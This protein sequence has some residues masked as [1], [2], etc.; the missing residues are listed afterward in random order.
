MATGRVRRVRR[1]AASRPFYWTDAELETL[2]RL[3]RAHLPTA[4]IARELQRSP[5]AVRTKASELGLSLAGYHARKR[6]ARLQEASG[7]ADPRMI[8]SSHRPIRVT[9]DFDVSALTPAER[10][11]LIARLQALEPPGDL[12][13]PKA[14]DPAVAAA[15]RLAQRKEARAA[16]GWDNSPKPEPKPAVSR[17]ELRRLKRAAKLAGWQERHFPRPGVR[18]EQVLPPEVVRYLKA[19][20]KFRGRDREEEREFG[21]E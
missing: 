2:V 5:Q 8:P 10:Q 7:V 12:V 15:A 17:K 4:R 18:L 13:I 11:L 3:A 9:V 1:A 14:F 6:A 16:L 19:L 20:R 21:E